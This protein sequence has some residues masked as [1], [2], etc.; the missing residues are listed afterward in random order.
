[1]KPSN[2]DPLD[3]VPE[4]SPLDTRYRVADIA[5]VDVHREIYDSAGK[6]RWKIVLGDWSPQTSMA[7]IKAIAGGGTFR[8]Q[9][10]RAGN[11][12]LFTITR[13]ID[14]KPKNGAEEEPE[15]DQ[16]DDDF[17][18]ENLKLVHETIRQQSGVLPA[19][20][21]TLTTGMVMAA[22]NAAERG[23]AMAER[24]EAM[25]RTH[26]STLESMRTVHAAEI[27]RRETELARR[28]AR[29]SELEKKI[30]ELT[31][32][33]AGYLRAM[34]TASAPEGMV[35]AVKEIGG[36][37]KEVGP[38]LPKLVATAREVFGGNNAAPKALG[39]GAA[40]KLQFG[41]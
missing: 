30:E 25:V 41:G 5:T 32:A 17:E 21:Q 16:E 9:A 2:S 8:I 31:S 15:Q 12:P 11:K 40:K 22:Q 6:K 20:F 28:D 14:G 4:F 19:A 18:D 24:M 1:M 7:D 37:I 29:I 26:A 33:N 36:V 34:A 10:R 13:M 3:D 39:E 35:K 23:V 38:S 27:A